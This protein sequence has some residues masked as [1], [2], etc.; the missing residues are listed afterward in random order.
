MKVKILSQ[1]R[2]KESVH[3]GEA[4]REVGKGKLQDLG[5]LY[6]FQ[7]RTGESPFPPPSY[8][9]PQAQRQ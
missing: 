7:S 1:N 2:D 4:G 9:M 3:L 6:H 8:P 5:Q